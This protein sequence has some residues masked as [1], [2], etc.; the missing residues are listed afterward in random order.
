MF[1]SIRVL[2]KELAPTVDF[3]SLRAVNETSENIAVRQDV[4]Q[5][6]SSRVDRGAMVTVIHRGGYGYA[7]TSDL[8]AGGLK[9]ALGQAKAWAAACAKQPITDFSKIVFPSYIGKYQSP[10]S[11]TST[12]PSRREII[13]LLQAESAICRIDDRIVDWEASLWITDT[14]QLYLSS[15]GGDIEQ[16]FRYVVPNLYV[17]ANVGSDTQ[18]RS[19][20]GRCLCQQGDLSIFLD[21]GM[22]GSG[23]RLAEETLELLAAPNC[24]SGDMDLL[25]MPSQMMLQIHESIGHPLE[26]DRILGDERNFA[27]TSFVTLDMFGHYLYGSELLNVSFDPTRHEEFSSYRW[28]DDGSLAEKQFVIRHGVLERSLGGVISQARAG[29]DGVAATRA[30]NWNR[31]PVDRIANLNIEPGTSTLKEMIGLVER[32]VLMDT[33][34]SWS[35]DDSRNKFQFG[36]EYGQLIENGELKGVL[37]NPNYRGVSATFWRSLKA[38]GDISTFEVMGTPFCG[39]AEPSQVIRVGHASPACLFGNVEIFGGQG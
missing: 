9:V 18:T 29:I 32:G 19:F 14:G 1:D 13:D 12:Q 16:E 26:L 21:S 2:F 24:P 3:C 39:K 15:D 6:L 10:S 4:L 37:K 30:C 17:S 20:G 23:R 33:N 11:V 27:G 8:S 35:I 36:C 25:L 31:P 28:D 34:I 38:V 5:P 22:N 7:A